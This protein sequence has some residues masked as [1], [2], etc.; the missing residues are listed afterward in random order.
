MLYKKLYLFL[1]YLIALVWIANGLFC[2]VLNLVPR[3]EEIVEEI[4]NLNRPFAALLTILIGLCEIFMAIWIVSKIQ[5]RLNAITQIVIVATMN[6]LEFFLVPD[7]LLWG[8]FN[9]LFA[10]VFIVRRDRNKS[11][12]CFIN[13][14]ALQDTANRVRSPLDTAE[15]AFNKYSQSSVLSFKIVLP[16][17]KNMHRS[18]H[19]NAP[20][21]VCRSGSL[22]ALEKFLFNS[23]K[24]KSINALILVLT[25]S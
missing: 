7:L 3:H 20:L 10:F 13:L 17:R 11:V 9:S 12:W 14:N 4:T 21:I 6:T 16:S 22:D 18:R 19:E 2:K 8:K 1:T 15:I 25:W 24:H 23:N 5:I